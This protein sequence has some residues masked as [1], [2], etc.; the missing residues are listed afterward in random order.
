MG[1]AIPDEFRREMAMAGDWQTL[2]ETPIYEPGF[3]KEED[4]DVKPDVLSV[5]VRKRK[6]EDQEEDEE[7]GER[8]GRKAWGSTFRTHSEAAANDE[9]D[10]D[11]LL[12]STGTTGNRRGRGGSSTEA[13]RDSNTEDRSKIETQ[14]KRNILP[15][16]GPSIK[17]EYSDEGTTSIKNYSE[18]SISN[19]GIKQED[20]VS[21]PTVV[22]KKRK[23]KP[24]QQK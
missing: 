7:D 10:L 5:G 16:D 23:V 24:I 17:R 4:V 2:S 15:G 22:F 12:A 18:T 1:V 19:V 13:P 11:T 6:Y 21:V 9:D 8:V 3:K 14:D 20:D